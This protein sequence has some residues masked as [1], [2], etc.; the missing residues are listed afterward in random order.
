MQKKVEKMI[1]NIIMAKDR[2]KLMETM[3]PFYSQI[4]N[5]RTANSQNSQTNNRISDEVNR[6]Y[7]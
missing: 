5:T 2:T 3:Q 6:Q 7:T 4:T 1:N